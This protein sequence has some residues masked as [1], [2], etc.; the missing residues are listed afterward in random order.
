M[1]AYRIERTAKSRW[2]SV[3]CVTV[4]IGIGLRLRSMNT[5]AMQS[6][7]RSAVSNAHSCFTANL[8]MDAQSCVTN[9][10]VA[11]SLLLDYSY[12]LPQQSRWRIV[13]HVIFA[14]LRLLSAIG[15]GPRRRRWSLPRSLPDF[16]LKSIV[17]TDES[18][19]KVCKVV[20]RQTGQTYALKEFPGDS[21]Q[22]QQISREVQILKELNHPNLVKCHDVYADAD[23]SMFFLLLEPLDRGSPFVTSESDLANLGRQLLLGL[24]YL[25]RNKI[26]HGDIKPSNIFV[27]HTG[28]V[29]LLYS[30]KT[31]SK[32]PESLPAEIGAVHDG[33]SWDIWSVGYCILKLCKGLNWF[34]SYVG[35]SG[36]SRSSM[37]EVTGSSSSQNEG[38]PVWQPS[39][40]L[41]RLLSSCMQTDVSNRWT[42]EQLVNHPFF[43]QLPP[44]K[45]EEF[46]IPSFKK[47]TW[48]PLKREDITKLQLK[49]GEFQ[50][51]LPLKKEVISITN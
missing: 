17:A 13:K 9:L 2:R 10:E 6:A 45:K 25:H 24:T 46:Q 19:G 44:L 36:R 23:A 37:D 29:K 4:F 31:L 20:H 16:A 40:E 49:T 33:F 3:R 22:S 47:E 18:S 21:C 8:Q 14:T 51:D 27:N 39:V 48:L 34:D 11:D 1:E 35:F 15:R 50:M 28:Q 41:L 7:T 5:A 30:G 43:Y 26:S 38:A 12:F 42:A 32:T